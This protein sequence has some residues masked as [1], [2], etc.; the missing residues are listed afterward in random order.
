[1]LVA[2]FLFAAIALTA[3]MLLDQVAK[4]FP[5]LVG[6]GLGPRVII[7]VFI[8]AIPF[9]LAVIIPM[10]VLAAV[11][12]VFNRLAAD[13]EISAMKAS[14]ISLWQIVR[15][16][17]IAGFALATGLVWFNDTVLPTANHRLQ[18]LLTDITNTTPTLALREGV[19]NEVVNKRLFI[20]P[21][22]IDTERSLLDDVTIFDNR[23]PMRSRTIYADSGTIR[24][25]R[26]DLYLMLF[27]GWMHESSLEKKEEF[28]RLSFRTDQVRI[29]GVGRAFERDTTNEWRGDREL[30]IDSMRIRSAETR[31]S[32]QGVSE[33]SRAL[34]VSTAQRLL[35]NLLDAGGIVEPSEST[36]PATVDSLDSMAAATDS[37]PWEGATEAEIEAWAAG[38]RLRNPAGVAT[39]FKT[40]AVRRKLFNQRANRYDVEIQKKFSIPAAIM[41][42]V[43]IG[44]PIAARYK[45]GGIALVVGVSLA[46][47]CAYYIAL[48][49]GEDLADRQFVSPFWAMWFT[50]IVFGLFALV[51]F[52]RQ[53]SAGA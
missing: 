50:N 13:N 37:V 33:E 27:D 43:L 7:E 18:R 53:R 22:R 52:W 34:S 46:V 21:R 16:V 5:M 8:L 49:V 15:P 38:Q 20:L 19:V 40:R 26:E 51:M 31:M 1:M 12:Y 44:A 2:P 30:P 24:I 36:D 45:R 32:A 48:I 10:A 14:G 47:F 3:I 4:K 35:G 23:D 39:A 6:K 41:V 11:L 28:H 25:G 29:P 42:F 9:I 17:V